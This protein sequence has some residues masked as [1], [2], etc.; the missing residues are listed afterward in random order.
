MRK[1]EPAGGPKKNVTFEVRLADETKAAFQAACRESGRPAAQVLRDLMDAYLN[2]RRSRTWTVVLMEAFRMLKKPVISIPAMT[3][4]TA[5]AVFYLTNP[6]AAFADDVEVGFSINLR[7]E[8]EEHV[9]EATINLDFGV[10]QTFVLPRSPGSKGQTRHHYEVSIVAHE[11]DVRPEI[12]CAKQNVHIDVA[13]VRVGDG[14]RE[15]VASPSMAVKYGSYA[16][17]R[18]VISEGP[19]L[20]LVETEVFTRRIETDSA[21]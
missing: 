13:I 4:A 19:S 1:I 7:G 8:D 9:L 2:V 16:K 3:L 11:C 17:T 15:T 18:A 5:G 10:A 6:L 21:A 14:E 20:D 12:V